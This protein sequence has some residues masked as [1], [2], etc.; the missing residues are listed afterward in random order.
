MGLTLIDVAL[1]AKRKSFKGLTSLIPI[2]PFIV[3]TIMFPILYSRNFI[4]YL[5]T[6]HIPR[7][8]ANTWQTSSPTLMSRANPRSIHRKLNQK[9]KG[10]FFHL[11][12]NGRCRVQF[13][14]E[15]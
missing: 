13:T 12:F 9:D 6:L 14:Q 15:V 10:I 11:D 8:K 7:Q 4:S 5:S 3:F 1:L 2:M